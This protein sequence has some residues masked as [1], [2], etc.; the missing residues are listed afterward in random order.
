M[1]ASPALSPA[2]ERWVLLTLA[3]INFTHIVDFMVL[4]PLGPQLTALFRISDAQFGLL[5]AAYTLAA[6]A[7]GL[8]ATSFID[9]FDRKPLLLWLYVGFALATL[10]CGVAPNYAAL[11]AARIAAG[12]FGGVMGALVQ[13]IVGDVVPFER[14]GR[15]MGM[16]MAAFSLATVAGVPASLWLAAALG[17]HAPF[18]AIAVAS[19]GVGIAALRLLPQLGG[20]LAQA[21]AA[22]PLANLA[23]V[24]RDANHWRAFVLTML[25]MSAGFSIIPYVTIYATTNLGIAIADVPLI[26][27]V[28]GVA[29]FFTARLFG[30]LTDRWGKVRSFR[31][32][33][34]AATVPMLVLTHMPAAP[35][36]AYIVVTTF[37]FVLVSGRMV[38]SMAITTSA[39]LPHLRGTFMSLNSSVQSLAMGL[40]SMV[41][42]LLI[43]RNAAGQMT[44][45]AACGWLGLVLSVLAVIWVSRVRMHGATA[46]V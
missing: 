31:A 20:H 33:A 39:A 24:L 3:A 34:L 4:M 36:A 19:A 32:L 37:F 16:V 2:R 12:L 17:W 23:E 15:A 21:R 1:T 7:S 18:I 46:T 13:T 38:P 43:H 11:L 8:L 5:V 29:T 14:R 25:V 44:G 40:A 27:L 9:R 6:G 45:Y 10:A 41:G 30:V 26:Y 35:L 28:G 22:S 42:G